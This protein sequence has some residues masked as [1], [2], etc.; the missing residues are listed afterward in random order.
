MIPS[1]SHSYLRA[2]QV[3]TKAPSSSRR[4]VDPVSRQFTA[5]D[6]IDSPPINIQVEQ[7]R[8]SSPK[9][10]FEQRRILPTDPEADATLQQMG[11]QGLLATLQET[12]E[13]TV[14]LSK[15]NKSPVESMRS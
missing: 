4:L 14:F 11:S 3:L 2:T 5:N 9:E 13:F 10:S 1:V 12:D 15:D 7:I 6:L 8:F